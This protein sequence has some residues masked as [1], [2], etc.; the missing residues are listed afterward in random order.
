MK[1]ATSADDLARLAIDR[2]PHSDARGDVIGLANVFI[3]I[4]R[5]GEPPPVSMDFQRL[6]LDGFPA[7]AV[8]SSPGLYREIRCSEASVTGLGF[9]GELPLTF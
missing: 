1:V 5:R 3:A 7:A 2:Y 8:P 9:T 4:R 6:P